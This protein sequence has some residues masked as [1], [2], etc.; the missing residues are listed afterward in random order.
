MIT[1]SKSTTDGDLSN[2]L[3]FWGHAD[4]QL[5]GRWT[6]LGQGL[7]PKHLKNFMRAFMILPGMVIGTIGCQDLAY[8]LR[9]MSLFLH[10]AVIRPS[11]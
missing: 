2:E 1:Y 7:S 11:V 5:Q 10:I 3:Y 9:M 6:I 8:W 4:N